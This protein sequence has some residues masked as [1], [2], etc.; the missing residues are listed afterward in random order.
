MKYIRFTPVL[1]AAILCG[2]N[3][4]N[5]NHAANEEDVDSVVI[6]G[7][8]QLVFDELGFS[9]DPP[10]QMKDVSSQSKGDFVLNYGGVEN[11]NNQE[12]MAVYQLIVSRLPIGYKDKSQKEV[13]AMADKLIRQGMDKFSNVK[14]V[15]VGYE[16]Y[17]GYVGETTHQGLKQK[18]VM[19]LKDNIIVALTV[20]TNY[21]MEKRFNSFTNAFKSLDTPTIQPAPKAKK[22]SV[23]NFRQQR[24]SFGYSIVAPCML[25]REQAADYDFVYVGVT[26][27]VDSERGKLFKVIANSLPMAFSN[28]IPSDQKA[29][30]RNLMSYIQQK[31]S[32][33][34][35][36]L[37]IK[38]HLAYEMTFKEN[39][40]TLH[41]C[42]LLTDNY[43]VE[44]MT[45]SKLDTSSDFRKFVNSFRKQ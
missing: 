45:A 26:D 22:S 17:P 40:Y 21:M 14:S 29:I 1:L 24:M 16:G 2:C 30:R 19:F 37:K 5:R 12:K 7:T 39:G 11:P 35:V 28:M 13:A 36:N 23:D 43:I 41:E 3:P 15:K 44:I 8:Y 9:I 42:L 38:N 4:V 27:R 18:G 34:K 32:Y 33:K 10:C 25:E 6:K 20:M 31:D